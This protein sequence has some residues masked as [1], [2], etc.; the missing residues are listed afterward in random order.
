MKELTPQILAM[1]LGVAASVKFN[2]VFL[3]MDDN[4]CFSDGRWF[5]SGEIIHLFGCGHCEVK[6]ILR[7][8]S[9]MS[10]EEAREFKKLVPYIDHIGFA[11]GRWQYWEHEEE[12]NHETRRVCKVTS[13]INGLP[14]IVMPYLL[15]KSFD[16][17]G[18]IDSGLAIEKEPVQGE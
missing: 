2:G 14:L 7:R 4:S 12:G 18:L 15:S 16:L 1:Y 5:I 11:S 13:D 17:F 6:P 9:S 10:E 8:L 3:R